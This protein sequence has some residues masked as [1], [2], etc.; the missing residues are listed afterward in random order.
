MTGRGARV[1]KRAAIAAAVLT[2]AMALLHTR[3]GRPL[4][5][6]MS[7]DKGGCPVSIAGASP[8]KLESHRVEAMKSL[9][10]RGRAAAKPALTFVLGQST[11]ADVATWESSSHVTCKDDLAGTALRCLDVDPR[12]VAD[13]SVPIADLFFR[14]DPKGQLVALDVMHDGTSGDA[15][16]RLFG[17]VVERLASKLG[18]PPSAAYG[19]RTSAYLTATPLGQAT[20]EYR[21]A[22]YAA[23]VSATNF[24]DRGVVVREQYRAI[25]D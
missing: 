16:V 24:G 4:L 18:A 13:G 14:F 23:D 10:G 19:E 11:R 21:F 5:A 9:K 22:D 6:R 2:G 8:E 3:F 1:A 25:P 7:G 17:E 12:T 20:I 15:A